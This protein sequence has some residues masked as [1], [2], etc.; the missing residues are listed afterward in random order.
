MSK[1]NIRTTI[2]SNQEVSEQKYNAIKKDNS[3]LYQ[4]K[5]CIVKVIRK[6]PI[7]IIRENDDFLLT[8]NFDKKKKTQGMYY[9]KKEK[10][11]IKLDICTDYIIILD[12]MIKIHYAITNTNQNVTYILEEE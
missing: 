11:E 1:I 9:L 10:L 8:L 4:E 7:I 5:E 12:K 2:I 6:D 3:Y